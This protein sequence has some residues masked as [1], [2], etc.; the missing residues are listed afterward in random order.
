MEQVNN[1]RRIGTIKGYELALKIKEIL[2]DNFPA[3]K[4]FR[5]IP[6]IENSAWQ[7]MTD[8]IFDK[9]LIKFFRADYSFDR[10]ENYK[11]EFSLGKTIPELKLDVYSLLYSIND[12]ESVSKHALSI[13]TLQLFKISD[14]ELEKLRKRLTLKDLKQESETNTNKVNKDWL[15]QW[16]SKSDK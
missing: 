15:T 7:E 10:Q 13:Y 3:K 5:Q 16:E 6:S 1:E 14:K 9:Y 8:Y 2:L 4:K 12:Y 11:K